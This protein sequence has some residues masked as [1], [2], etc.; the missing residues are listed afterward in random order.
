VTRGT[1]RA[2]RTHRGL[3]FATAIAGAAIA[4]S[5]LAAA[6]AELPRPDVTTW[7]TLGVTVRT[8][9]ADQTTP[10]QLR[11]VQL[12]P[13]AFRKLMATGLYPDGARLAA[14]FF[15]V[16]LDKAHTPALYAAKERQLLALEIVD[17]SVPDGRVFYLFRGTEQTARALP[18]G[19]DCA[20]CHNA[21]GTFDGTFAELYPLIAKLAKPAAK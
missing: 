6:P 20:Q 11:Q 5:L 13:Y 1:G 21:K 8:N 18:Q 17:R 7:I 12:E 4:G 10:Q 9:P 2:R 14:T 15:G 16:E 3:R 19:N